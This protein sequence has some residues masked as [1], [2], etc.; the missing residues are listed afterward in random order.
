MSLASALKAKAEIWLQQAD[1]AN[2]DAQTH[3]YKHGGIRRYVR[4]WLGYRVRIGRRFP[5]NEQRII[6][7]R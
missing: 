1:D 2:T 6:H 7:T 4:P 5:A 3:S